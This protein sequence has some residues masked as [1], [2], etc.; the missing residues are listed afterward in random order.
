MCI[1]CVFQR[2]EKRA[3]ESILLEEFK[4]A[5]Q[6]LDQFL[7]EEYHMKYIGFDM[8]HVNK[9]LVYLLRILLAFANQVPVVRIMHVTHSCMHAHT[10]MRAPAYTHTQCVCVTPCV[11]LLRTVQ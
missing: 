10:Y 11:T 7:P 4:A 8:A 2:Q 9:R 1:I 3:H 5:I 6:Y